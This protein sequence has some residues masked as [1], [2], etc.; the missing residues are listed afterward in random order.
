M[1][2]RDKIPPRLGRLLQLLIVPVLVLVLLKLTVLR[3][4][5]VMVAEVVRRNVMAEVEG[6]GT[7]TVDVLAN[8]GPKIKGRVEQVLVDER[9]FVQKGQKVAVLDE[10]DLRKQVDSARARLTSAQATAWEEQREWEREKN[11]VITGAVSV[12]ESQQYRKSYQVAASA[13]Q[14]AEADL[15]YAEYELSLTRIPSLVTGVVTKRWVEPGDTVVVGQPMFTVADTSLVYVNANIDQDFTGDI[16][17]DQSAVVILRG[18]ENAPLRGRVFRIDP[19]ADQATEEMIAE[20]AFSISPE[21]FQLGQWAQVYIEVGEARN[22]LTVPKTAII[23][24]GNERFVFVAGPHDHLRRIAVKALASSPRF[25][26]VAIAGDLKQGDRVVVMPMG[27]RAGETV[28]VQ[29]ASRIGG[30]SITPAK[31]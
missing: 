24:F 4:P 28:R 29:S 5:G 22:A 20:V 11:L 8:V 14:A 2:W 6:T 25:P 19:E 10:T 18:R 26:F 15:G 21:E 23:R 31:E 7:V 12:E 3:P 9:D 30:G 17:K 13:V 16:R 27:L 1:S